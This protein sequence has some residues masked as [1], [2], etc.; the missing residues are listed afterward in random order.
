MLAGSIVTVLVG[1]GDGMAVAAI[2]VPV[3]LFFG[4]I[5][6]LGFS[7]VGLLDRV[8][9]VIIVDS[10]VSTMGGSNRDTVGSHNR[11]G[12]VMGGN[13]RGAVGDDGIVDDGL[14][15]SENWSS[16]VDGSDVVSSSTRNEIVRWDIILH[17]A[18]EEDLGEG[19]TNR[20][21]KFI[22]VLVL[23]LSLSIH[24]LVVDIL[25]VN[26]Q[27]VLNVEDE[28]PRVGESLG[29]LAELVK[30]S[31]DSG[32]AFLELVSNIVNDV[33][34]VL[35]RVQHRVERSMLELVNN[36]AESLPDMLGISQALNT[37]RNLSLDGSC[38]KTFKD[39]AHSKECEVDI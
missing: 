33:T 22:E 19:K 13:D 14:V 1:G 15:S 3:V 30:I 36:T 11:S 2:V 27:V 29:H 9:I 37:V 23:P 6:L 5:G 21:T 20:V 16:V 8:A 24:D 38:E 18:T 32:F 4:L 25:A 17:L 34:Q 7:L 10:L 39:L 12:L 28:V 31:S 35:N 26:D